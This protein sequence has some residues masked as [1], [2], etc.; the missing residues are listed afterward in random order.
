MWPSRF[1]PGLCLVFILSFGRQEA[2]A[3]LDNTPKE[4]QGVS[5]KWNFGV[6]YTDAAYKRARGNDGLPVLCKDLTTTWEN[7][8][9][10]AS[11]FKS[12]C[13]ALMGNFVAANPT[14]YLFG[15]HEIKELLRNNTCGFNVQVQQKSDPAKGVYACGDASFDYA[16]IAVGDIISFI[17]GS[18]DKFTIKNGKDIRVG[19]LGVVECMAFPGLTTTIPRFVNVTWGLY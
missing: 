18:L 9:S 4:R 8:S 10:D 6:D 12:D 14:V 16:T 7:R 2:V 1:F 19:S 13:D 15:C 17:R 3:I 11:P 5:R